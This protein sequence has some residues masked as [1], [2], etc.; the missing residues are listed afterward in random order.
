MDKSILLF[1]KK[2]RTYLGVTRYHYE[3]VI[4]EQLDLIVPITY[5]FYKNNRFTIR[6]FFF[7]L[8]CYYS[9]YF[10][11]YYYA[12]PFISIFICSYIFDLLNLRLI[13]EHYFI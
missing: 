5:Y 10:S 6:M 2:S 1:L 4:R 9:F 8:F 11:G 7:M 13:S 3:F 12:V